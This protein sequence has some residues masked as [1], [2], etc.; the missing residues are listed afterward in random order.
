MRRVLPAT[1]LLLILIM[2]SLRADAG[3][4]LI[5]APD[6]I[7][8]DEVVLS[9]EKDFLSDKTQVVSI[10]SEGESKTLKDKIRDIYNL[11]IYK[12]DEPSYLFG[13]IL[14][15]KY[16]EES[17]LEST[18]IWGAYGTDFD[19]IFN[20][21]G[22]ITNNY[23]YNAVNIGFDGKFKDDNADFRVMMGFPPRS[24]KNFTKTMF[25]DVFIASNRIPHHRVQAGYYRPR[26]GM[27]GGNSAYTLP[28][29]SR[30]QISRNFG[31]ARKIGARIIGDYS[32]A[33]YDF[34]V[35][36]SGT[37]FQD[38]FPGEE[39]T[40]W[41]NLKP[42]GNTYGKYGN[43]K[44]GT[45]VDMGHRRD[46]FC[47]TG[48]Y[49]G[50]E[51]KKF[52]ADVEWANANGYNGQVNL[53]DV[54]KHASGFYTTIGYMLTKKAQLLARYDVFDPD[55]NM[56]KNK[57]REYSFGLNYFIK[58]QALRVTLNYIFCQNDSMRNSHRL[59]LGT[60]ILF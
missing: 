8:M 11:E 55:K 5:Q 17:A 13:E 42:L 57:K 45:G 3:S 26:V 35:Y 38:Y 6:S 60:Q 48:A 12:Y 14:T 59:V 28:F 16:G 36:S 40:G 21:N 24:H 54:H 18:H 2:A 50:Y 58:G 25:A 49:A 51:Y 23:N 56:M 22:T 39:F 47:V 33:D 53:S 52:M 7:K 37:F 10:E 9:T 20:D 27:E 15:K 34:G 4:V 29:V 31:T 19:V 41:L 1:F 43:L 44:L 32:L 46:N 30:A